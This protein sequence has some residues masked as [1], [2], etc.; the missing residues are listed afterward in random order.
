MNVLYLLMGASLLVALGFLGLFVWAVK[1]GQFED[2]ETPSM[3]LLA[4]DDGV[5]G[6][7]EKREK[8]K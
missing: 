8:T 6:N 2:S 7:K 1:S 5:K 4:E 3:R